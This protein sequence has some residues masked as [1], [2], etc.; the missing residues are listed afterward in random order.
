M[1]RKSRAFGFLAFALILASF[2]LSCA[3]TPPIRGADGK[4]LPGSV[5][6]IIKIKLGGV[7]Q[8]IL[9]R[10]QDTAKPVVLYL[11]GGPGGALMPLVRHYTGE[12]ERHA[13]MAVWD[14][15]GAGKSYSKRIPPESMKIEQYLSD[16][17]ELVCYLKKRF[18]KEKIHLIGHS[19]GSILGMK[20]IARH[21]GDFYSYVG[22]GQVVNNQYANERISWEYAYSQAKKYNNAQAIQELEEIGPPFEGFYKTDFEGGKFTARGLWRQR[23][24]LGNFGGILHFDSDDYETNIKKLK[25][26]MRKSMRTT[27]C[28]GEWTLADVMRARRGKNFS[29]EHVWPEVLKVD[30]IRDV[31]RV[32]VPVYFF[33]G[34]SDYNTPFELVER[35]HKTLQAPHQ[36]IVWFEK[37][38]HMLIIE[39][40]EKFTA[41]MMR[42]IS[43]NS[44]RAAR[45]R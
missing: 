7:D 8:W 5:S 36:E 2:I 23:K 40:P 14:Q 42:V 22:I 10:G 43:E 26:T 9:L 45:A 18:K 32:E 34:R 17:D 15:R 35:Y 39:E 24:W 3:G 11:H 13:I 31:P 20:L 33:T 28:S 27:L 1:K 41:E 29:I 37:S 12:L 25:K 19:W 16:A 6:E 4:R 30:L 38:G 44:E 21:P